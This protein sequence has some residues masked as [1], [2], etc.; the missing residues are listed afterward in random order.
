MAWALGLSETRVGHTVEACDGS[1]AEGGRPLRAEIDA[2]AE[3]F[4]YERVWGENPTRS[5][6]ITSTPESPFCHFQ[7]PASPVSWLN[8]LSPQFAAPSFRDVYFCV[9]EEVI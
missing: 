4:P 5:V 8:V 7:C 6:L 3:H 9:I 2:D 1:G